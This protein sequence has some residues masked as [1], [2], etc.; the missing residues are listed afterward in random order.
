MDKMKKKI[1]FI[2][3]WID[4]KPDSTSSH[5]VTCSDPAT[6]HS[7]GSGSSV[8][9]QSENEWRLTAEYEC[10]RWEVS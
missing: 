3:F 7:Q 2:L 9:N 1:N 10:R 5:V 8:R 6:P 4:S